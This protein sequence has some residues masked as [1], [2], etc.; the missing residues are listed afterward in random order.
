AELHYNQA[1]PPVW[2]MRQAGRSAAY[3]VTRKAPAWQRFS[4]Q[5]TGLLILLCHKFLWRYA[6]WQQGHLGRFGTKALMI[7]IRIVAIELATWR[8]GRIGG[9]AGSVTWG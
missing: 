2:L 6:R 7:A 8:S 3:L 5:E 4:S 9:S 1:P